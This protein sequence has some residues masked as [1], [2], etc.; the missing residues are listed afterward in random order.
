[1]AKRY[2]DTFATKAREAL[3]LFLE[4]EELTEDEAGARLGVDQG[5]INRVKNG[6]LQAPL[7]LL[8]ALRVELG[9]S[10]DQ[11]LD[12]PPLVEDEAF[13]KKVR[14]VLGLPDVPQQ[15]VGVRRSVPK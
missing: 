5:T 12:L 10:I 1:M 11:M 8:I 7:A 6:R 14:H 3:E 13:A 4:R 9:V 2:P 15:K